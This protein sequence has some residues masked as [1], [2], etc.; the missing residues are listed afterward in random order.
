MKTKILLVAVSSFIIHHSSFGQGALT[1]PGAPALTMKTLAQISAQLDPRTPISSVP[2]TINTPGSYY[3]TTNLTTTGSNP[4]VITANGVTLDLG[5]FTI[6]STVASAANGGY[7]ILLAGTATADITIFNGHIRGGVT[8]NGNNVYGGSGF[9]GGIFYSGNFLVNVLVSKVSVSG[10][11]NYGIFLNTGD[12][13]V[14]EGCTAQT[15]GSYGIVASTVKSC[16][17]ADCG[18]NAIFGDQVSDCRGAA[19]GIG[20]GISA[21][22]ALNCSGVASGSGTGLYSFTAQNCYGESSVGYGIDVNTAQNCYGICDGSGYG[23][24]ATYTA[25][26][27]FGYSITGTGLNAYNASF[28]TGNRFHGTAIQATIATGCIAYVGTNIVT[29]KYNMP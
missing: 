7:A 12:S 16:G 24:Y 6:A 14:V 25:S 18:Y 28:C 10:C 19:T 8:N 17:V 15:I 27:C 5:G 26:G 22:T 3:L 9:I 23:L 29:Y 13:T 2:F 21:F 11:L 20:T 1:P 4:I